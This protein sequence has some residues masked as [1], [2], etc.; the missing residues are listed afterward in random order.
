MVVEITEEA[1]K[2]VIKHANVV[3]EKN[4]D[5]WVGKSEQTSGRKNETKTLNIKYVRGGGADLTETTVIKEKDS[6]EK[7]SETGTIVKK[8]RFDSLNKLTW[9]EVEFFFGSWNYPI[10]IDMEEENKRFSSLLSQAPFDKKRIFKGFIGGYY[11]VTHASLST[12]G[13]FLSYL[14]RTQIEMKEDMENMTINMRRRYSKEGGFKSLSA[15]ITYDNE[16]THNKLEKLVDG[17]LEKAELDR[18]LSQKPVDDWRK[19][20]GLK[21]G[22][23]K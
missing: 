7:W 14:E 6:S 20:M 1:A 9:A 10:K 12:E 15:D 21:T 17:S 5:E 11:A 16:K 8:M 18:F 23:L 3:M 22:N 19:E 2:Q 4:G 13:N